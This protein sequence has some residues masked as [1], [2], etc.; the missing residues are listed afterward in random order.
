MQEKVKKKMKDLD[1]EMQESSVEEKDAQEEYEEMMQ[2]AGEKRAE[3]SKAITSKADTKAQ[4]EGD[5]DDAKAAGSN[6]KAEL[7]ATA[8]F[9]AELHGECAWLMKYADAQK[10][11]RNRESESLKNAKAVLSGA[12]YSF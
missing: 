8:Q 12:D 6:A 9:V 2:H 1:K 4:L 7:A 5:L 10:E 3:D 11:A